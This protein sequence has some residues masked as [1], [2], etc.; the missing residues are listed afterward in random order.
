MLAA[1]I[2]DYKLAVEEELDNGTRLAHVGTGA[3]ARPSRAQIGL[4]SGARIPKIGY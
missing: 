2:Y 1:R 3:L 4:V